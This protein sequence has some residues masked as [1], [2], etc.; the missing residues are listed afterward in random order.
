MIYPDLSAICRLVRGLAYIGCSFSFGACGGEVEVVSDP[1]ALGT[2]QMVQRLEAMAASTDPRDAPRMNRA[3]VQ[4]F[5][6]TPAPDDAAAIALRQGMIARELLN[7]GFT[8]PALDQLL[9]I[10][11][12]LTGSGTEPVPG[13]LQTL[14]E[15]I[16]VALIR[17]GQ[18]LT[19]PDPPSAIGG[20]WGEA[21]VFPCWTLVPPAGPPPTFSDS[22]RLM[23]T[24]AIEW[25]RTR[26][27]EEP[28]D[29]RAQWILNLAAMGA[30]WWPDSVAEAYRIPHSSLAGDGEF[31]RFHN[32][33]TAVGLDA[34]SLSG[35]GV[36]DDFNGDGFLDVMASSSG[37]GDQLRY[38]EADGLGRF[39]ERT[40]ESGLEGLTGGINLLHADYDNDGDP[41][42]FL[43]RGAWRE[44]GAPNSLLRN[45]GG[46]FA[47]VTEQA[48][49]L[50]ELPSQTAGWADY[51]GDGWL[52]LFV[53]NESR[54]GVRN[55]SQLFR[56][57]G[58]GTF[59][60]VAESAGVLVIDYVKGVAWGDYDSDGRID[61]YVSILNAPNRLFRN[62]G[63]NTSGVWRFED[64]AE[65]AGVTEPLASFPT[66]FWDIDNDGDLDLF[67]SGYTAQTADIIQE[68]LGQPHGAELPKLYRNEGNGTFSDVTV[69][70]GLDRIMYTMGS[71]YGDLD[72]DGLP[73]FYV[74]TGD[75][76]YR[77]LMPNRMFRNTGCRFEE[78]TGSG[79]FGTLDKG[80]GVSFAD[81][82]HD[83]DQ[84]IH[85]VLGG[86]NEGDLSANVLY[87]NP[88]FGN[89]WLVLSLQGMKA[90]R[91]GMGARISIVVE[92]VEGTWTIHHLAGT[93]GMFGGNPLRQEI[94][95]GP[96]ERIISIEIQW[97]GSG[98]VDVIEGLEPNQAYQV[99]EGSAN[100]EPFE[101]TRVRLGRN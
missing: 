57:R 101:R 27:E 87:E 61:L 40:R 23:L 66:W 95:L 67:V 94:G 18:E 16:G 96:A 11:E 70:W 24:R 20:A 32:V 100:A 77:Q 59:E 9:L 81:M 35:G 50:F 17:R 5:L 14:E 41:D 47:D 58:D 10:R 51:D 73:D 43:V 88:G 21:T 97:P 26:L 89:K 99:R 91:A 49:L 65:A 85:K 22:A 78:V 62:V 25:Q 75:P 39:V 72:N 31:P 19:C 30:G 53:P 29:K 82:D 12:I 98:T 74:G 76:D 36:V 86:A 92:G 42:V 7:A 13:F 80:H 52:D 63:P 48:G 46:R 4:Y 83:G 56:N 38:F 90:N 69:Q 64:M 37:R 71:N 8:V 2:I 15:I 60:E 45:D 93:G 55:P 54:D 34:V 84:D 79:G 68:Y 44:R 1:R 6:D 3:R 33:A 28:G